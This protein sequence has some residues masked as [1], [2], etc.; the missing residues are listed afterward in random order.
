MTAIEEGHQAPE[1]DLPTDDGTRFRLSD[2]K[3]RPVVIYFYP[4]DDTTGCTREAI[5]FSARAQEFAA[6]DTLVVGVSPD[7][8]DSH[9]RFRAK[10]DLGVILAADE[11]KAAAQDFQV[12]KER[13]M[14]GRKFMGVERSTFLIGRDGRLVRVWRNVKVPNHVDEVLDA[15]RLVAS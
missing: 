11:D 4:K 12:W 15:A 10:H 13:S 14:Y 9:R 2:H 7:S 3:G 1:I 8:P 5:E 6:A